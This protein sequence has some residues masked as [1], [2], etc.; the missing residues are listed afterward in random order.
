[1]KNRK[2]LRSVFLLLAVFLVRPCLAKTDDS[3]SQKWLQWPTE[4]LMEMVEADIGNGGRKDTAMLCLTIVANRYSEGTRVRGSEGASID[5]YIK[6][7]NIYF[8]DFYDYSKCFECLGRAQEIA[9]ETHAKVPD[10]YQGLGCMYLTVA[11]ETDNDEL[12]RKA[13]GYYAQALSTAVAIGDT[14]NADMAMT[15]LLSVSSILDGLK[16]IAQPLKAYQKIEPKQDDGRFSLRQYNLLLHEAYQMIEQHRYDNAIECFRRQLQMIPADDFVRLRYFTFIEKAKIEAKMQQLSVA[17]NTLREAEQIALSHDMKDCKLETF[18][19]LSNF[20]KRNGDNLQAEAYRERCYLLRDTLTN[21]HQLA[22]VSE[23]EFTQELHKM[24]RRITDM[25]HR[26]QMVTLGAIAVSVFAIILAAILILLFRKNSQLRQRNTALYRKNVQLLKAEQQK[27]IASVPHQH[28]SPNTP[29]DPNGRLLEQEQ[30]RSEEKYRNSTLDDDTKEQLRQ[31]IEEVM[32]GSSEIYSP[33]FSIEQLAQLVDSKYK[34]VSQVI[35]ELMDCNFSTLLGEY[36]VKEACK[37]IA[38][39]EHYAHLT[40][41][42]IANSVGFKS[43]SAFATAFKK[44]TGLT[45]S[46]YQRQARKERR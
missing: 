9:E 35:N 33:D 10:I 41:E 26:H 31:R 30:P 37:R 34:Y 7:W 12:R 18:G 39:D 22:S 17:I 19:L 5:A 23:M 25:Q 6:L 44:S 11:E 43:R 36:R 45:P 42:G 15:S 2:L 20:L 3:V 32:Q 13:L 27:A 21:Y 8:Y 24:D 4:K 40:I 28:P 1:M 16:S 14:L 46:E 38:D 29:P